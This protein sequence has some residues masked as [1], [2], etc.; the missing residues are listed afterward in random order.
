MEVL[1]PTYTRDEIPAPREFIQ[2]EYRGPN[3]M[4]VYQEM[5]QIFRMIW[6]VKG[7][8]INEPDFRWDT[9]ADPRPFFIQL[10][11]ERAMDKFTSYRVDV[12]MQGTQPTDPTKDGTLRVEIHGWI[13]TKFELEN[14][15][16]QVNKIILPLIWWPYHVAYYQKIRRRYIEWHRRRINKLA[17]TIREILKI[18]AQPIP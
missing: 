15:L 9:T 5:N 3:P 8:Q 12:K 18:P 17:D 13:E 10:F 14:R 7:T 2:I 16:V 1:I 4:K 6:E 11:V